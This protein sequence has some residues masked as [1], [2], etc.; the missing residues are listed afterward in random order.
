[1]A[2]IISVFQQ[3]ALKHFLRFDKST[4]FYVMKQ[5]KFPQVLKVY[6]SHALSQVDPSCQHEL[7]NLSVYML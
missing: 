1:M 3:S 5:N 4:Y 7:S 2:D 6:V